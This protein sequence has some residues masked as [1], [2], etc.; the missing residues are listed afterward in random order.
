MDHPRAP[1]QTAGLQL[2]QVEG[3]GLPHMAHQKARIRLPVMQMP[4]KHPT[5]EPVAVDG[6][7]HPIAMRAGIGRTYHQVRKQ[8]K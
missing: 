3:T 5:E 6:L 7:L 1:S 2:P 8:K 4:A